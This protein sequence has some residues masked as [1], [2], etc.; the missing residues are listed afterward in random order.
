MM[1]LTTKTAHELKSAIEENRRAKYIL[2]FPSGALKAH[3]IISF[4]NEL[5]ELALLQ[6]T[7]KALFRILQFIQEIEIV[8]NGK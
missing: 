2:T 5:K 3:T 1:E 6:P 8:E 4:K 7:E